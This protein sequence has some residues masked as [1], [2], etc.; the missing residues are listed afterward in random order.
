MPNLF[1][2]SGILNRGFTGHISYT[3]N[4][5]QHCESLNIGLSFDKQ[6]LEEVSEAMI[7]EVAEAFQH[8]FG[9]IDL[10]RDELELAVRSMKTEI[11][12]AAF[13]NGK[14][15]GGIHKQASVRNLYISALEATEGAIPTKNI[16]GSLRIDL[17]VFNVLQDNTIYSLEVTAQEETVHAI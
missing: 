11:Q 16:A 8:R 15:I 9:L 14:F 12:L 3:I 1:K 6:R 7:S 13:L 4:L 17:I 5:K 10:S 2:T